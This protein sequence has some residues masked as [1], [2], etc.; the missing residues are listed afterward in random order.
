MLRFSSKSSLL[1][2]VSAVVLATAMSSGALAT[3]IVRRSISDGNVWASGANNSLGQA[4]SGD[5]LEIQSGGVRIDQT[6]GDGI[7]I[8][9]LRGGSSSSVYGVLQIG[10]DEDAVFNKVT[11]I[12]SI[13]KQSGGNAV[14]LSILDGSRYGTRAISK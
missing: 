3:D 13:V 12:G 6:S 5:N 8:G 11:D 4:Q 9:I 7:A 14:E 2:G 10:P 1:A